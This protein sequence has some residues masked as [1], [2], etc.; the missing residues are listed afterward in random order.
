MRRSTETVPR[1]KTESDLV[2][3]STWAKPFNLQ[4]SKLLY[5]VSTLSELLRGTRLCGEAG[6]W[7]GAG[8]IERFEGR[9][10]RLRRMRLI[11]GD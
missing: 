3:A 8:R 10:W 4:E 6:L 2:H 1:V 11:Y 5:N 7:S 9:H